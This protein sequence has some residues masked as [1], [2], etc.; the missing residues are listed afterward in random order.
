MPHG[1]KHRFWRLCRIYFRRVRITVWLLV[2]A[3]VSGLVYL[4]QVGLPAFIKRPLLERLRAHGLDMEFSRLRLS[5]YRGVLAEDVSLGL[6]DAPTSPHVR[7][8]EVGVLL[9]GAALTRFQLQ[10]DSIVIRKGQ[11]TFP[12]NETNDAP[13]QLTIEN[14]QTY[15]R[16]LPEDEWA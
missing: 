6:V 9:N 7:A 12:I 10:V 4:N 11:V 13:R 3:L 16:F 8:R 5:W 15:L 14:I 2:L 1:R